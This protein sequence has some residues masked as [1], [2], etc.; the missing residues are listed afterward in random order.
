[1][2]IGVA[3][4][5]ATKTE[6]AP[7]T[8]G[9]PE[10]QSDQQIG[11]F[12]L[13]GF[14]ERG[15]KTWDLSGKS[16]DIFADTVKL[17]QIV[18]TMYGAQE[19]IKLTAKRGDFD[20]KEGLVHLEDDV[21]I[22]TAS[23]A[24][25]TTDSLDWDRKH[26]LVK[27]TDQVN[28]ERDNMV[29]QA[30][31]A[32]GKTDLKQV[33]LEKDV[34]VDI[35]P[36]NQNKPKGDINRT[37]ITITCDGPLEIDYDKNIATFLNN[38][39]VDREDS[40]IYSDRMDVYFSQG[41]ADQAKSASEASGASGGVMSSNIEKIVSIGN[42]RIVRGENISYSDQAI[43]TAADRKITLVGKPRL[44]MFSTEEMQN[45]PTGN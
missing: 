21:V 30:I 10:A 7:V 1:M 34:Q 20:K 5:Q 31:G 22:T 16:A 18:G 45:A 2:S 39:K 15:K 43:Y 6:G 4:A 11:D 29:S 44:I 35:T 17:Q 23:G 38:V 3:Q 24:R 13:S 9:A 40:Q 33:T 12:S 28:I 37:K 26:N 14:G 25:M 41:K 27:T 8:A 32:S 19:T 36:A 42:V